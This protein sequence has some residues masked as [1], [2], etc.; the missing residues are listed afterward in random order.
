MYFEGFVGRERRVRCVNSEGYMAF[1]QGPRLQER[2]VRAEKPGLYTIHFTGDRNQEKV[3][4]IVPVSVDDSWLDEEEEPQV[5]QTHS[6]NVTKRSKAKQ[7]AQLRQERAAE[8]R[9]LSE[10]AR[11]AKMREDADARL[12]SALEAARREWETGEA[13]AAQAR[14]AS[15]MKRHHVHACTAAKEAVKA[16]QQAW[17]GEEKK[18]EKSCPPPPP[19]TPPSPTTAPPLDY[20]EDIC[21]PITLEPMLEA[22]T[23]VP[24]GHSFSKSALEAH[25]LRYPCCPTCR[26]DVATTCPAFAVQAMVAH[27]LNSCAGGCAARQ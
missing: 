1:Y 9:Q 21:C 19:S 8:A 22:L 2:I 20:P 13:A 10:R 6:R 15:A 25:L 3:T 27:V 7:R 18:E 16:Q 12:H 24:C 5:K 26:E 4:R 23:C 11:E 17:R 14:L